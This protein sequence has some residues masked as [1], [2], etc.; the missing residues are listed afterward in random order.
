MTKEQLWLLW[1][2]SNMHQRLSAYEALTGKES[3]P[4]FPLTE[5]MAICWYG[6]HPFEDDSLVRRLYTVAQ[7]AKPY[8]IPATDIT[9]IAAAGYQIGKA[10]GKREERARKKGHRVTIGTRHDDLNN[11]AMGRSVSL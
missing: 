9:L 5:D 6:E 4:Q 7:A 8:Y 3:R 11:N 2:N 1:C 10:D